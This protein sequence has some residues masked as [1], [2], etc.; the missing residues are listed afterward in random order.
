MREGLWQTAFLHQ[1][2]FSMQVGALDGAGQL[3]LIQL[4]VDVALHDFWPSNININ[5][6]HTEL[7]L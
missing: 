4:A 5:V 7:C 2:P 1:D 6:V 3:I